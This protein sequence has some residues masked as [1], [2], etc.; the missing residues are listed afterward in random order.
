MKWTEEIEPRERRV[1]MQHGNHMQLAVDNDKEPWQHFS[2]S[3]GVFAKNTT[4]DEC[5][6]TWPREAIAEA[7]RRLD[8]FE[9]KLDKEES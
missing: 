8:E 7:R 3:F 6:R 9:A 2:L 1:V 4:F 5:L